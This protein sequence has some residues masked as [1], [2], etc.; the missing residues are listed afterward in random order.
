MGRKP[1]IIQ[2]RG[3]TDTISNFSSSEDIERLGITLGVGLT[4]DICSSGC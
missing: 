1:K 2:V 3:I 4:K